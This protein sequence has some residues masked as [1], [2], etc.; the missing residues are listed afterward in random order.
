MHAD[1]AYDI[2]E[3]RRW[4]ADRGIGVRIARRSIERSDR[5]GRHRWVVERSFS[6]LTGY[7]RLNL[8]YDRK[9]EHSLGFLTLAPT[10]ACF[11]MLAK[12]RTAT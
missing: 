7:H 6:W 10:L 1:K 11:K 3:L 12:A 8:R 5:L 9:A 4:G 2:A